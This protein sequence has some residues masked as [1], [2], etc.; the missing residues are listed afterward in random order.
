ME[1]RENQRQGDEE[2]V[3]RIERFVIFRPDDWYGE[4]NDGGEKTES[5]E[6]ERVIGSAC[7]Y[8]KVT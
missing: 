6:E 4:Q 7:R 8:R 2:D 1:S 5:L 3:Q